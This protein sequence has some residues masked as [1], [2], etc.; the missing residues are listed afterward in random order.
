MK[1]KK[2]DHIALKKQFNKVFNFSVDNKEK[3]QRFN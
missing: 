3:H 1:P 2:L